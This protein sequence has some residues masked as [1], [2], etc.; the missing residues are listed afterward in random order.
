MVAT[1]LLAITLLAQA[2][3]S[4]A[5]PQSGLDRADVAYHEL[6]QGQSESAI[7]RLTANRAIESGDPAALINLGTAYA[8]VGKRGKALECFMA[9][10]ASDTRY[11]LQLAD[12]RWMDSRKAARMAMEA[13]E[14]A[15]NLASR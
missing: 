3:P 4:A 5:D 9:A 15:T 14:R 7:S 1:T 6:A 13:L 10:I 11:D 2:A 8:R 12:G